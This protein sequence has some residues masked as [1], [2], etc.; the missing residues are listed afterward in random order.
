MSARK[1]GMTRRRDRLKLCN[2]R[3]SFVS[4]SL[5]VFRQR[6]GVRLSDSVLV[7]VLVMSKVSS[8]DNGSLE[9]SASRG[10]GV[11]EI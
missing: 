6:A 2:L 8:S 1:Y 9:C 3:G 7:A 10:T 4:G 5:F 11:T